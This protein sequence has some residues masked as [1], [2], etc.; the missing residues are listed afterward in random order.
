MK[1]LL[2]L[3]VSWHWERDGMRKGEMK[4]GDID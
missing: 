1:G 3:V 2:A 4:H